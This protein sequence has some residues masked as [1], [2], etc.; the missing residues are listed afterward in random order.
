MSIWLYPGK[1]SSFSKA[2]LSLWSCTF[3]LTSKRLWCISSYSVYN[4]Q[5]TVLSSKT[6]VLNTAGMSVRGNHLLW[7][8]K[9]TK[10][11]G[12]LLVVVPPPPP[13]PTVPGCNLPTH[14]EYK[15]ICHL[16][17]LQ[18]YL[19]LWNFSIRKMYICI[20][21]SVHI[22]IYVYNLHDA[23]YWVRPLGSVLLAMMSEQLTV[24]FY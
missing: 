8:S 15:N 17:H 16:T 20:L 12:F 5:F 9:L 4:L 14:Y 6:G 24:L 11:V 2:S 19:S 10:M 23:T 21:T 7:S 22:F 1:V 3:L 13:S 18:K